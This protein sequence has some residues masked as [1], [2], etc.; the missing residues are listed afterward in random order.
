ML[1]NVALPEWL[2]GALAESSLATGR[3]LALLLGPFALLALLLRVLETTVSR[4]LVSRLGFRAVLVTGWLGVPV[5]EL[6]HVVACVLFGHKVERVQLFAP[7]A[8]T[9]TLGSVR[10]AWNPRNPWAQA[11]R[12]VIGVAPLLGGSAVLWWLSRTLGPTPAAVPVL[13]AASDWTAVAH[14]AWE[15]ARVLGGSFLHAETWTSGRTWLFLY[16]ALC[17]GMH[18]A[19]SGADLRGARTGLLV[20]GVI[21]LLANGIA[22]LSGADPRAAE[23]ILLQG[24]LPVL[25]LLGLALVLSVL[26]GIAVFVLTAPLPVRTRAR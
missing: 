23:S 9:A 21:L 1:G 24:T 3:Q 16:L 15:H 11:G 17:V 20:F 18:S 8:R 25:A 4:R 19:P 7:D 2:P 13:D 26:S 10:H 6:S 14:G 22:V 5:H 12:L